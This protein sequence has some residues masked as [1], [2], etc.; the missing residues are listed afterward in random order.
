M[1]QFAVAFTLPLFIFPG[2]SKT[3]AD[4]ALPLSEST[5]GSAPLLTWTADLAVGCSS[6]ICKDA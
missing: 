6:G 1:A 4:E 3:V 2:V 5:A